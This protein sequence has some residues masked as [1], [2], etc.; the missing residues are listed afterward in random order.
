MSEYSRSATQLTQAPVS[1]NA[2]PALQ[3]RSEILNPKDDDVELT[4]AR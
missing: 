4:A 3:A 2:S 1:E